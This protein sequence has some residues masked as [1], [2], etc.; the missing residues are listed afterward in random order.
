MKSVASS[1][2]EHYDAPRWRLN[3]IPINNLEMFLQS[4]CREAK[5]EAE[6]GQQ[7]GKTDILREAVPR[8]STPHRSLL[9]HT[10]YGQIAARL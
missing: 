10:P 5:C 7:G 2:G 3:V 8:A 6:G 9:S 4:R 1:P